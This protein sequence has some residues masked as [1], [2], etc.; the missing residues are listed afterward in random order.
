MR[1][2]TLDPV[3]KIR[4]RQFRQDQ[5]EH[6]DVVPRQ[7]TFHDM[8]APLISGLHDNLAYPF[9]HWARQSLITVFCDPKDVEPVVKS[10]VRGR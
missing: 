5:Q 2:P 9:P 6:M 1:G 4:Q 10:R 3:Q 8:G 7:H